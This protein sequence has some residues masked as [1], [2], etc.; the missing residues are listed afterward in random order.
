VQAGV[1]LQMMKQ[2]QVQ[3]K[4]GLDFDKMSIVEMQSLMQEKRRLK[5]EKQAKRDKKA[6]ARAMKIKNLKHRIGGGFGGANNAYGIGAQDLG[7]Q[8][9]SE[10][11]AEN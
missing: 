2:K 4:K 7:V 11:D 9:L 10:E 3:N 8:E 6:K 1:M 5:Q